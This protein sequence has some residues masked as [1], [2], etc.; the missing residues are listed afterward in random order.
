MTG[1]GKTHTMLGDFYKASTGEKGICELTI[2]LLFDKIS[3]DTQQAHEIKMSYLEIYNEQV[4]DLLGEE[5][6]A[7]SSLMIV[8]DPIR[9]VIVPGLTE[10]K[11][12]SPKTLLE[13]I[14]KGN[15]KRTMAETAVNQFS[16]RSHAILQLSIESK[17]KVG[18]VPSY[19]ISKLSLIDLAGSERAAGSNNRGLRLLEGAKINR[20]LLA[21]GACIKI[22]S[23]KSKIGAFVP[24]RDSKLTRLL[25]E[26]LG[27]NARTV[28]IACVS[29]IAGC[30]EETI[31]TLKYAERAK[32]IKKKIVRNVKEPEEKLAYYKEIIEGLKNEICSL[33][34]Q[35]KEQSN[36]PALKV[37]STK[38]EDEQNGT[39]SIEDIEKEINQPEEEN[40]RKISD[41]LLA[42][43]EEYCEMKQSLQELEGIERANQN[44]ANNLQKSID[45]LRRLTEDPREKPRAEI[46]LAQTLTRLSELNANI[47]SN[48]NMKKEIEESLAENIAMQQKLCGMIEK[49]EGTQKKGVIELQ[50][51]IRTLRLQ[52]MDL[53]MQNMEMKKLACITEMEREEHRRQIEEMNKELQNMRTKLK[54]KDDQ[55]KAERTRKSRDPHSEVSTPINKDTTKAPKTGLTYLQISLRKNQITQAK[56]VKPLSTPTLVNVKNAVQMASDETPRKPFVQVNAALQPPKQQNVNPKSSSNV[57]KVKPATVKYSNVGNNKNSK[58]N[59]RVEAA[60]KSFAS[61]SSVTVNYDGLINSDADFIMDSCVESFVK[62]A[63][64]KATAEKAHPPVKVEPIKVFIN[65]NYYDVLK[66]LTENEEPVIKKPPELVKSVVSPRTQERKW[67]VPKYNKK[68]AARKSVAGGVIRHE[69]ANKET[70]KEPII[71]KAV[72]KKEKAQKT[73]GRNK[74]ITS[75]RSGKLDY[76]KFL[77]KTHEHNIRRNIAEKV[78]T[79]VTQREQKKRSHSI[80]NRIHKLR[81]ERKLAKNLCIDAALVPMQEKLNGFFSS[82]QERC[83]DSSHENYLPL[84][85]ARP[86]TTPSVQIS[87]PPTQNIIKGRNRGAGVSRGASAEDVRAKLGPSMPLLSPKLP[88]TLSPYPAQVEDNKHLAHF[89][90]G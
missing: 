57:N 68:P 65:E 33:K 20:S 60:E 42:K 34:E 78:K 88:Y 70:S 73:K 9:G 86:D 89:Q 53:V 49:L 12:T 8:E 71:V 72:L 27:G 56:G 74:T 44:L 32:K 11:I 79:A 41:Y 10:Y 80:Q 19:T 46:E 52:N 22:L 50:I 58:H 55:L 23:D 7:T 37:V 24:Y 69:P 21:L 40:H 87:L 48:T 3:T 18:T 4:K 36:T 66:G 6:E 16:S 59:T 43:Y 83:V 51:A 63:Q 64:K 62:P 29:P 25:K 38:K 81:D 5:G 2:E 76:G 35:L 84:V 14:F 75:S 54:Q 82:E 61:V 31:N 47:K 90:Y 15:Q 30:Y 77:D 17:S 39:M 13:L 85:S 28:M 45:S 67:S 1:S 26:S